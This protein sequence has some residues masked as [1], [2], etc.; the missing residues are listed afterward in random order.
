MNSNTN[1]SK[2]HPLE[3][4]NAL[5]ATFYWLVSVHK[6]HFGTLLIRSVP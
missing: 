5:L 2:T 3:S 4:S 6:Q 1:R